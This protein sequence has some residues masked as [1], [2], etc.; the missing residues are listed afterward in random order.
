VTVPQDPN[1]L[2]Y[3][4]SRLRKAPRNWINW[5]AVF[6]AINGLLLAL[7]QDFLIPAGLCIP[8]AFRSPSAH[9]VAALPFAA[10]AYFSKYRRSLLVVGG[11]A[12]LLDTVFAAYL[13]LWLFVIM[14]TVVFAFA[15]IALNGL[16]LL[17]RQQV[18]S[19][20]SDSGA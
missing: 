12:Y 11:V 7:A 14:H 16:R 2:A 1:V 10:L 20:A 19:N 8:F 15:A 6:T 17:A 18:K 5:I 13:D 3:Q 4:V 9:W